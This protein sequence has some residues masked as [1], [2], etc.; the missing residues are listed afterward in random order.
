MPGS[1]VKRAAM[2]GAVSAHSIQGIFARFVGVLPKSE[3]REFKTEP[4]TQ[5]L[6]PTPFSS[7]ERN[8]INA[9]ASDAMLVFE[10]GEGTLAE[11]GFALTVQRPIF[12]VG[13]VVALRASFNETETITR[14]KNLLEQGLKKFPAIGGRPS[15]ENIA[16]MLR[17]CLEG[18]NDTAGIPDHREALLGTADIDDQWARRLVRIAIAKIPTQL[19]RTSSGFPD[20]PGVLNKADFEDWLS[21]MP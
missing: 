14:L 3:A 7:G 21:R 12:F 6:V 15:P 4:S 2:R 11:L 8:P 10:G 20:L 13:S 19:L 9:M 5:R 18:T 1:Q 16:N 17:I